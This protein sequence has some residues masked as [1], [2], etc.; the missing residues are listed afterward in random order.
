MIDE[1]HQWKVGMNVRAPYHCT[2]D[3]GEYYEA[4]I[5]KI[6]DD[7]FAAIEFLGMFRSDLAAPNQIYVYFFNSYGMWCRLR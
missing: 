4:K 1:T 2:D 5:L 6:Y 7:K 3:D